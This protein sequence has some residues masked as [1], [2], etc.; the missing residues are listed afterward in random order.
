MKR[1]NEVMTAAQ[2]REQYCSGKPDK[3][4]RGPAAARR[5]NGRTYGSLAEMKYAKRLLL[6]RESGHVLVVIEQPRLW[7]GVHQNVYVPDFFVVERNG[8][9]YFVDVKGA[10]TAKWRRDMRLWIEWGPCSLRV[11]PATNL[12]HYVVLWRGGPKFSDRKHA[13]LRRRTR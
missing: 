12:D 9:H 2:F 6:L 8:G 1:G 13:A 5:W 11:V 4:N 7:L 10:S 3:F